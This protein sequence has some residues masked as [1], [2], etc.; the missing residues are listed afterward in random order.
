MWVGGR[1]VP[2]QRCESGVAY[3]T[4]LQQWGEDGQL[5][6]ERSPEAPPVVQVKGEGVVV[7]GSESLVVVPVHVA[8]E[9]VEHGHVHEVVE[10][11][12]RVVRADLSHEVTVVRLCQ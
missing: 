7:E 8:H 3:E 10:S 9:E 11:R 5:V 4:T 12:T 6:V 2:E 1:D